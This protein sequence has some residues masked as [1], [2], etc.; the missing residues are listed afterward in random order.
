M[1]KLKSKREEVKKKQKFKDILNGFNLIK[2]KLGEGEAKID[3]KSNKNKIFLNDKWY[4]RAH[5]TETSIV[6]S[7]INK[8]FDSYV[9]GS[10]ND[11]GATQQLNDI[12]K[13]HSHFN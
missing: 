8:V 7:Q 1:E 6:K 2:E 4:D 5:L 12:V 13:S 10:I 9:R 3:P 11:Q